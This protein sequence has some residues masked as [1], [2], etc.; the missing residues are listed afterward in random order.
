MILADK[1]IYLRKK[2]GWSQEELAEKLG[3]TRQ[4]VSKWEGAQ[5]VPDLERILQL[6]KVFGVST[7]YLLKDEME[8]E[9]SVSESDIDNEGSPLRKV[10]MEE[11]NRFLRINERRA[12]RT[13]LGVSLC[14][15]SPIVLIIL[16]GLSEFPPDF[17]GSFTI[18]ENFAGGIGVAV[19]L[20]IIAFAVIIFIMSGREL[21]DFEYLE[22]EFI[23]TS[24]GV[25]G[26]AKERREAYSSKHTKSLIL[27]TIICIL[28]VIPLFLAAIT[29]DDLTAIMGFV[30]L[31]AICS[32]GVYILVKT[33]IINDGY[34]MLLEAD[35][36]SRERKS[37][38]KKR[39]D[40]MVIY[41]LI[42]TAVY[43]GY[44]FYS[45]AHF[46]DK[47]SWSEFGVN[48]LVIW[49]VAGLLCPVVSRIVKMIRK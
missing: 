19:L 7:D 6:G 32:V 43:I 16:A 44:V 30:M 39:R 8:T 47:G 40:I 38:K 20:A 5:S 41:W 28:S 12:P 46:F 36:Y 48:G 27:G 35:D 34:N 23:D 3:V 1:I 22:N 11:A 31:L 49:A 13:A 29:D 25:S 26:M 21:R 45:R 4:S 24:Y 10:S 17:F 42:V 9:E 14:I 37:D 18:S 15:L 2:S 33:S